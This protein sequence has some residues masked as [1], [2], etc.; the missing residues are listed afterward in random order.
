MSGSANLRAATATAVAAV[1]GIRRGKNA[2]LDRV[3]K[4]PGYQP[5][6]ESDR[7][8]F[9]AWCYEVLRSY[10]R[11]DLMLAQLLDKPLR[12]R[13]LD[14]YALLLLAAMQLE[15]SDCPEHAIVSESVTAATRLR[16]P[17]MKG[18]VN[19]V[20]RS[21]IDR[22]DELID[23]AMQSQV[24]MYS[25]PQWLIDQI[26]TDWPGDWQ[27]ILES[28]N[29]K[30]PMWIRV[31]RRKNTRAEYAAKLAEASVSVFTHDPPITPDAI[32][33]ELAVDVRKLPGFTD[34]C[35]SVQDAAA[36][37][38]AHLLAAQPGMRVLDACAAPGGKTCHLL[39]LADNNLDVHAVDI[40]EVRLERVRE[41]L[42]RLRLDASLINADVGE[43]TDWWDGQ[44]YQRILLDAPCSATGV[45][46]R[47]P[48]IKVLRRAS[49]IDAMVQRQK[50]LLESLWPLLEKGG[51][52]LYSSCSILRAEN[53]SQIECF[54]K[55][56]K[57]AELLPA[58]D[59]L[60][61][62]SVERLRAAP[63][64]SGIQLLPGRVGVDGFFYALIKK[65]T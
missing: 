8:R 42:D 16:K 65:L 36:Q 31:N 21:F 55:N 11:L 10:H 1:L 27:E 43:I 34:G 14:I 48:D 19:A 22:R 40:N 57:D 51:C 56:Q 37:I 46:R 24:G 20:L 64:D 26:K 59:S 50:I 49:D 63:A 29:K 38:A 32:M 15:D 54:L 60:T 53:Q 39:E 33:L 17:R 13:D 6:E 3:L 44:S 18:L 47:H 62:Q 28:N 58:S 45:I 25:H 5:K 7:A 23:T 2:S 30:A 52:M 9:R 35:A 61:T 12:R 4:D 41:N